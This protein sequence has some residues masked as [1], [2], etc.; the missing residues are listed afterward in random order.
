VT[1]GAL[2]LCTD[3]DRT[4]IPNGVQPESSGSMELFRDLVGRSNVTLAYVTGRHRE[5][6]EDA[7]E[8]YQLPQPDYV[9]ADVGTTIYKVSSD[10][11]VVWDQWVREISPAWAGM[12]VDDIHA[13]LQDISELKLQEQQKQNSFKLSYYV[14][15]AIELEALK[16]EISARLLARGVKAALVWSI[17]SAAAVG[18]LDILPVKA[19]KLHA[20]EFLMHELGFSLQNTIFAGDSGNDLS[21]LASPVKS[22]LVANAAEIVREEAIKEAEASGHADAIYLAKGEF[23]GMNGNYSAGIV[24]GVVHYLPHIESM[25]GRQ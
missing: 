18:L 10:D 19:T 1:E 6:V 2:L 20:I 13:L 21:V 23:N 9:V 12:S 15:L 5:L 14:P 8:G 7:I 4:L 25:L 24:E 22:I 3:L 17:D 11:W 16:Q